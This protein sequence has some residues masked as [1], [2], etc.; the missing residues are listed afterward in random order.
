MFDER[1]QDGGAQGLRGG[2]FVECV[3]E[4][5]QRSRAVVQG[6]EE[7]A[8]GTGVDAGSGGDGVQDVGVG[9]A[10]GVDGDVDS[11]GSEE[12][13][14]QAERIEGDGAAALGVGE[15]GDQAEDRG[16]AGA[17]GGRDHPARRF[18]TAGG[19]VEPGGQVLQGF[20]A[21]AE[22]PGRGC[23]VVARSDL[24]S[25]GAYEQAGAQLGLALP[26]LFVEGGSLLEG[27]VHLVEL[28]VVAGVG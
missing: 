27:E 17:G 21:A 26:V 8:D 19:G 15:G 11:P 5:G 28:Y 2:G 14:R 24:V 3:D 13:F 10:L 22:P 1:A 23:D 25:H 16:L 6:V 12:V 18:L 7:F 4:D 9:Q 20:V